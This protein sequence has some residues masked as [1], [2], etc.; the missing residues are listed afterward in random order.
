MHF[1]K[2]PEGWAGIVGEPG[3]TDGFAVLGSI[4][5]HFGDLNFVLAEFATL[6]AVGWVLAMA[7][8]RTGQLWLSMGLHGGWIFGLKYFSAVT[9]SSPDLKAGEFLPWV[10]VNLKI[11]LAP[12]AVIA[13]TG[14]VILALRARGHSDSSGPIS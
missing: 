8:L 10:G 13:L 3:W 6:F 7:R 4:L 12:L 1:L 9:K 11:G 14:V 2:P 5:G